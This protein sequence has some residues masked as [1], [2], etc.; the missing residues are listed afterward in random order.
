MLKRNGHHRAQGAPGRRVGINITRCL[1]T[2]ACSAVCHLTLPPCTASPACSRLA[3]PPPQWAWAKQ[4]TGGNTRATCS[5]C[6]FIGFVAQTS[7]GAR[8]ECVTDGCH[9]LHFWAGLQT[10]SHHKFRVAPMGVVPATFLPSVVDA[11]V[12]VQLLLSVLISL[13]RHS[14][15][16]RK[17]CRPH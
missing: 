9:C 11:I 6:R 5:H 17:F 16:P 1:S 10:C 7:T 15:V 8:A 14:P 2:R 4:S 13:T 12:P 3:T